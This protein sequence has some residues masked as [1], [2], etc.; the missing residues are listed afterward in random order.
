MRGRDVDMIGAGADHLGGLAH[1]G[2]SWDCRA[3]GR[4]DKNE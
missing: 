3:R 4:E 1:P 2:I